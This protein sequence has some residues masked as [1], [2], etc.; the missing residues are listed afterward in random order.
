MLIK[1][2]RILLILLVI[3]LTA[4]YLPHFFWMSF[5]ERIRAP[6]VQYSPVIEEFIIMDYEKDKFYDTSGKE[7]SREEVDTML[8]LSHYRL[9]ATKGLL[10]DSIQGLEINIED[11]RKN[12]INFRIRPVDINKPQI[13]L[14]Q[15]FESKP[16]RLKLEMPDEFFRTN[17]RMEFI[18]T[19][20][21]EISEE[22]TSSFTDLLV[23]KGFE[24]PAK[25][26][27]GNP[28]TRKAYDEGY[29]VID[30]KEELYHIKKINGN[31]FCEK[32]IIPDDVK[33]KTIFLREYSLKEF[34]AFVITED[35][36]LYLILFENYKFQKIPIQNYN[37]DE[38]IIRF[39]GNLFYRL[40][41]VY[42]EDQ[43]KVYVTNRKY[44]LIDTYEKTWKSKMERT[45]GQISTYIF[46]FELSFNS[47][48]SMY[49][50]FYFSNL[51]FNSIYLNVVLLLITILWIRK[52]KIHI[53]ADGMDYIIVLVTGIFG[54]IAVNIFRNED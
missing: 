7:Y 37:S 51:N 29:L 32:V 28:T 24:F 52:K 42:K 48:D 1:F 14:Y 47:S 35:N 30:N 36:K 22:L 5:S 54:F 53:I 39:Q 16:P 9:L 34:Y 50:D 19:E 11:I 26:C 40:V 41:T 10:P 12:Y 44:E 13:P 6:Y 49:I 43:L 20:N 33:I 45:A 27:Y 46:P 2:S 31:P 8:P 25:K 23:S 3:L 4:I 17:D 21:N 38:D 18:S 15:L